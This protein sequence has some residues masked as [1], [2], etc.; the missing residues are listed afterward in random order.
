MSAFG[1][2]GTLRR[3]RR[4]T[5][6][7][8]SRTCGASLEP[9]LACV[10][11]PQHAKRIRRCSPLLPLLPHVFVFSYSGAIGALAGFGAGRRARGDMRGSYLRGPRATSSYERSGA[12]NRRS[13][14]LLSGTAA[15]ALSIAQ[16]AS[17]I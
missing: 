15:V 8:P 7:D 1:E 2:T 10:S 11:G 17:A 9:R 3:H 16:P 13:A 6:S 14:I 4:M 12:L 5:E